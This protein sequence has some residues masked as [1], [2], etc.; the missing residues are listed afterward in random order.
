MLVTAKKKTQRIKNVKKSQQEIKISMKLKN[1]YTSD[2]KLKK[3]IVLA[4]IFYFSISKH[5]NGR[6]REDNSF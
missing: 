5:L 4:G 2:L 6:A 3:R 1:L